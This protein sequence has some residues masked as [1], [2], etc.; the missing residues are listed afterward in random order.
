[1]GFGVVGLEP[2]RLAELNDRGVE[3]P[4]AASGGAEV[5]VS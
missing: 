1:V 4:L 3:L 5:V 2:E